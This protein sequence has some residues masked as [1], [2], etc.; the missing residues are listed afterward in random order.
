M[1]ADPDQT[2][3]SGDS[4]L[5]LCCLHMSAKLKFLQRVSIVTIS[6]LILSKIPD[7]LS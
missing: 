2:P 7:F 3:H 4:E 6:N 1:S 5:G